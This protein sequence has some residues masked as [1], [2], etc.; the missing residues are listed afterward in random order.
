MA[1]QGYQLKP[2]Q[3]LNTLLPALVLIIALL[4]NSLAISQEPSLEIEAPDNWYQVEVILFTQNGNIGGE[5]PPHKYQLDFPQNWLTLV[6]PNMPLEQDGF[7]LAEGSLLYPSNLENSERIIPL[8][9]V[10][11]PLIADQELLSAIAEGS[12]L[13]RMLCLS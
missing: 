7:P 4:F 6:D 12:I 1:T 8:T 11:D 5:A 2:S 13:A 10:A 9:V 3:V